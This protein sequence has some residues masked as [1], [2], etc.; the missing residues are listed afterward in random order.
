[1]DNLVNKR[2]QIADAN[3]KNLTHF[4]GNAASS[5][6][7]HPATSPLAST[8]A[9]FRPIKSIII[10]A[11]QPIVVPGQK[12]ITNEVHAN[13]PNI[14]AGGGIGAAAAAAQTAINQTQSILAS[15]GTNQTNKTGLI[16]SIFGK[17]EIRDAIPDLSH[18]N[19]AE[20]SVVSVEEF[21]PDGEMLEKGFLD[22]ISASGLSPKNQQIY[23][24]ANVHPD[25]D[26]SDS[27]GHETVNP[28]VAR[29][30][31]EPIND[32]YVVQHGTGVD[33]NASPPLKVNPLAKN[34]NKLSDFGATSNGLSNRKSSMS[35]DEMEIP[36][37]MK[38]PG[39]GDNS[40]AAG[41]VSNEDFDSWL[42]DTNQRRSPEG[43]EDVASL[44][45]TD[46]A[47][48]RSDRPESTIDFV[49]GGAGDGD[50]GINK[51]KEKKHRSKKK[52]D[53]KDKHDKDGDAGREKKKKKRRSKECGVDDFLTGHTENANLRNDDAYEAF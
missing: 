52:K 13:N 45:S 48:I 53:K 6:S 43:G 2:R 49:G 21:C 37:V 40:S 51:E 1:M 14:A 15:Q 28:L 9:E 47:S 18:L 32:E 17:A 3:P 8:P 22:D 11:G 38:T 20:Q 30:H 16:S 34:K 25:I 33:K 41:C 12:N 23:R 35:S 4:S 5:V 31:D 42:S 29:F 27:D 39:S 44:P 50:D 19:I 46:K 26:D 24:Q 7:Q 36:A 10:G